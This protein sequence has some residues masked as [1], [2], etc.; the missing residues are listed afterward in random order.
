MG[1]AAKV[2]RGGSTARI[3]FVSPQNEL[4]STDERG[5]IKVKPGLDDHLS[6]NAD[7]ALTLIRQKICPCKSHYKSICLFVCVS[8]T[9]ALMTCSGAPD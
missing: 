1:Y 9:S 5:G 8:T 7:N 2:G 3:T 6:I 4:Y